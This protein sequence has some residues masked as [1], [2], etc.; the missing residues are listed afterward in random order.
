VDA[1]YSNEIF[2][3]AATSARNGI[4][5]L[6]RNRKPLDV[7]FC[8]FKAHW[9]PSQRRNALMNR[10][11]WQTQV[12]NS[13]LRSRSWILQEICLSRRNIHFGKIQVFW[14]CRQL[15]TCGLLPEGCSH[16][17]N[18]SSKLTPIQFLRLMDLA[19]REWSIDKYKVM[20]AWNAI[21]LNY[22]KS[23]LIFGGNKLVAIS[24]LAKYWQSQWEKPTSYYA[25]IW[26]IGVAYQL[27]WKLKSLDKSFGFIAKSL[28]KS[29]HETYRAPTW[30]RA[31][32]DGA[33]VINSYWDA[34]SLIEEAKSG[35]M[36]VEHPNIDINLVSNDRFGQVKGGRLKISGRLAHLVF[37]NNRYQW[38]FESPRI[39]HK[40]N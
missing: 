37:I 26:D 27:M 29:S 4:E 22:T 6:F 5:G 20:K 31:C 3:I 18:G 38:K 16:L 1:V 7:G 24:A 35:R 30:S 11:M 28:P 36:L 19:M 12:Q 10:N 32:V 33:V 15:S 17:L 39:R 25:G 23:S 34:N 14:E 2:N 9:T 40:R 8:K 21:V 13:P